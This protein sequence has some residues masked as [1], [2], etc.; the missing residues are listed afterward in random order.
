MALTLPLGTL[1]VIAEAPPLRPVADAAI[2]LTEVG[3]G[4]LLVRHG[5]THREQLRRAV[6]A[7]RY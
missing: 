3:G 4:L 1:I 7:A 5:T 6:A 2:L